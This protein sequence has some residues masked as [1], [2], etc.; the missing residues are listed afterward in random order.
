M[1]LVALSGLYREFPY[2]YGEQLIEGMLSF[3]LVFILL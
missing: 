1:Q 2:F 3:I